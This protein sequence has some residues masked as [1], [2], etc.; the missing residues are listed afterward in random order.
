LLAKT[1]KECFPSPGT[2]RRAPAM[3]QRLGAGI[4]LMAKALTRRPGKWSEPSLQLA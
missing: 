4:R 3:L 2:G 1:V